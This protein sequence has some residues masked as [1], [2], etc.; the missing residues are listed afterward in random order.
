MA[1]LEAVARR[2]ELWW[3]AAQ[4]LL[5]RSPR[6][7]SLRPLH[8]AES[9]PYLRSSSEQRSRSSTTHD[10]PRLAGGVDGRLCSPRCRRAERRSSGRRFAPRA[11]A[12][13][14]RA[15][16][17]VRPDGL[18]PQALALSE[19]GH[20]RTMSAARR[21]I[22]VRMSVR[23]VAS[24]GLWALWCALQTARSSALCPCS[25]GP[26]FA[27]PPERAE[28]DRCDAPRPRYELGRFAV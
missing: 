21:V 17:A 12:C 24:G 8:S 25:M 9:A 4:Q 3:T 5:V 13:A 16:Y 19:P 15:S 26:C 27:R 23:G 10:P 14:V 20:V 6:L 22:G 18:Q 28:S 11:A 1:F 2:N 7:P